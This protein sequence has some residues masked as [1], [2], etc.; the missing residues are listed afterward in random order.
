MCDVD[1][2][3][4]QLDAITYE[5]IPEERLVT[6]GEGEAS[7]CFDIETILD[8]SVNPFTNQPWP[9]YV[10]EAAHEY[11]TMRRTWHVRTPLESFDI[12]VL[13]GEP[14]GAVLLDLAHSSLDDMIAHLKGFLTDKRGQRHLTSNLDFTKT[15]WELRVDLRYPFELVPY[16]GSFPPPRMY[17]VWTEYLRAE[18]LQDMLPEQYR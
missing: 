9:E 14:L 7:R 10:R 13:L 12:Q 17:Q 6:V 8:T 5:P 2:L 3:G 18:G 4:R 11:L 15:L 1:E 16:I